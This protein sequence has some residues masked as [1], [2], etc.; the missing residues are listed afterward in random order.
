MRQQRH[1]AQEN[2]CPR[3]GY[4]RDRRLATPGKP[5]TSDALTQER[6]QQL[7]RKRDS[8]R[9]NPNAEALDRTR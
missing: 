2:Q 8:L 9:L 4:T 6:C 3:L 1:S 7:S 5:A